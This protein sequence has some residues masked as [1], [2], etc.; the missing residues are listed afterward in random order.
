MR[1]KLWT[2]H[3]FEDTPRKRAA[4]RRKQQKE[5]DALPLFAEQIAEEQPS[6]DE[7]MH[8][9]A[10]RWAAHEVRD[11]TARAQQWRQARRELDAMPEDQGKVLR[12]A[13]NC[14]PYPA[15][16]VNLLGF[17]H[18]FRIG[19]I[20]IE[21][22]PFPLFRTD[23]AGNRVACI[24]DA[25]HPELLISILKARDIA[26]TS[27]NYSLPERK[28]AYH[29][30]QAAAKSNKVKEEAKQ[31]RLR[32]LCVWDSFGV[33]KLMAMEFVDVI[34]EGDNWKAMKD[35]DKSP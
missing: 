6:E 4:L 10:E 21:A 33:P 22:L 25:Q 34:P 29:H 5:R 14:A 30:L 28:A 24:F 23:A 2:R 31:D 1:F 18:S 17:L 20:D 13:W 12:L 32:A 15:S 11:R 3:A 8:D 26:E 27:G 16:P 19:R 7:V 9:R 35:G